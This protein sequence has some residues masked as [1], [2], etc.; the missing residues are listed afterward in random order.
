MNFTHQQLTASSKSLRQQAGK[1]KFSFLNCILWRLH[2]DYYF[3]E[4]SCIDT[5][6]PSRRLHSA[7]CLIINKNKKVSALDYLYI[8]ILLTVIPANT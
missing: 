8:I 1:F 7:R 4:V 5:R 2:T 3:T 6:R